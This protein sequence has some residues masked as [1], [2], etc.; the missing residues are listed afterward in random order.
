MRAHFAKFYYSNSRPHKC[1]TCNY[2]ST[3]AENSPA[4]AGPA[5]PVPAPMNSLL[6]QRHNTA[7]CA[8][9]STPHCACTEKKQKKT[10]IVVSPKP[11]RPGRLHRPWFVASTS[12]YFSL[13]KI[14]LPNYREGCLDHSVG[15]MYIQPIFRLYTYISTSLSLY[16]IDCSGKLRQIDACHDHHFHRGPKTFKTLANLRC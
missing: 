10:Q 9:V 7:L 4:M 11:V 1:R 3:L 16:Y 6:W 2:V 8:H 12:L 14:P 5:G 15:S 13:T